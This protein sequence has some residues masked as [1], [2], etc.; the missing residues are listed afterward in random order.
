MTPMCNLLSTAPGFWVPGW[1]VRETSG[2]CPQEI[3]GLTSGWMGPEELG[4]GRRGG[5]KACLWD[6]CS[7]F[8]VPGQ[9]PSRGEHLNTQGDSGAGGRAAGL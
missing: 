7:H 2:V 5:C 4:T 8:S 9:S 6:S 1:E 3:K